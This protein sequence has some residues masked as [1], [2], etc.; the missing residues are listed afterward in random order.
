[1][2]RQTTSRIVAL[3]LLLIAG[4]DLAFPSLCQ[5]ESALPSATHSEDAGLEHR[6]P[7]PDAPA[8]GPE[9]D[10]FCCCVHIRPQPIT[11]GIEPLAKFGDRLMPGELL[12]PELRAQALFHPPRQ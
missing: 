8:Q 12:A 9:E 1:M 6:Q 4:L 11:R 5:A 3:S 2:A 10:C 7:E